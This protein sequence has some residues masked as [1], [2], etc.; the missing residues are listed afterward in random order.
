MKFTERRKHKRFDT[1]DLKIHVLD[2]VNKDI[3][4]E[5]AIDNFSQYGLCITTK[6]PLNEGQKINIKDEISSY[7]LP[8]TVRWNKKY[9]GHYYKAGLE[10]MTLQN[11]GV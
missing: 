9:N 4:L 7:S 6:E 8:A 3:L 2:A 10:L 5:G 11:N 1:L